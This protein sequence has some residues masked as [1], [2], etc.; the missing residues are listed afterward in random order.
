[1][2]SRRIAIAYAVSPGATALAIFLLFAWDSLGGAL[3]FA[4]IGAI[5]S[6]GVA[7]TFGIACHILLIKLNARKLVWY[8]LAG[9][10]IGTV[11]PTYLFLF[12]DESLEQAQDYFQ[13]EPHLLGAAALS[14]GPLGV[15]NALAFWLIAR[16]DRQARN[17]CQG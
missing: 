16:P 10:V 1:M 3:L 7:L 9:F 8:L 17:D 14:F 11:V 2:I 6:Y 13:Y 12:M 15:L 5:V 4:F